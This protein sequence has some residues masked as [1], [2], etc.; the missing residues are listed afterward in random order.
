M[1]NRWRLVEYEEASGPWN[2]AVDAALVESAAGMPCLRLY[3]WSEPTL[4]LGYFQR[5]QQRNEHPA[6]ESCPLVRRD[7]GG[8]AILHHHEITYS[9]TIGPKHPLSQKSQA[10]YPLLHQTWVETLQRVVGCQALLCPKS[11]K[12]PGGEPFLCFQRRAQGDLLLGPEKI[13][14]SAQRRPQQSLL[15]HG[16]LLL[17]QSDFAP[18]LPGIADITSQSVDRSQLGAVFLQVLAEKL[19]ASWEP[20]PLTQQERQRAEEFVETKYA[21][22]TWNARR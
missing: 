13:G 8:G 19:E 18:E 11:R 2:M 1:A 10:L 15:Q 3:G 21:S 6:S 16:S 12:H 9:L 17:Q 7:S 22:P 14:G 5:I 20:I 4:S